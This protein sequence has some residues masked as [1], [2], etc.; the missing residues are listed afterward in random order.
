MLKQTFM[1]LLIIW[2]NGFVKISCVSHS[3]I[4]WISLCIGLFYYYKLP[5]LTRNSNI[6]HDLWTLL[7]FLSLNSCK[8][9]NVCRLMSAVKMKR[10]RG[11]SCSA[12]GNVSSAFFDLIGHRKHFDIDESRP[13]KQIYIHKTI[14]F[15]YIYF[16]H[17]F[18]LICFGSDSM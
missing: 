4:N 10:A 12:S 14:L 8:I 13:L 11:N 15:I 16:R 1:L 7:R 9:L 2:L 18:H 6:V 17:L 5:N 3:N